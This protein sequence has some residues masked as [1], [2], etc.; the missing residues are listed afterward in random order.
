MA[1][2]GPPAGGPPA[3]NNDFNNVN[4]AQALIDPKTQLNTYIYDY[5]LKNNQIELARA[6]QQSDLMVLTNQ[7]PSRS[8]PGRRDANGSDDANDVE[9][10]DDTLKRLDGL[11]SAK[12]PPNCP[13]DSFLHD[14]WCLFWDIWDAQRNK[15]GKPGTMQ[16]QYL[17]QTQVSRYTLVPRHT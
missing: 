1:G 2:I 7:V 5:F 3:M 8:S 12:V 9:S 16:S 4:G 15:P 13:N 17:T 11:P 14:W 10:K 6:L